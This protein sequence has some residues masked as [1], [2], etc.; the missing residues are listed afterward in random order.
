MSKPSLAGLNPSKRILKR[1][2]YE[3]FEFS[4]IESDILVRNES[5]ADPANHE[6]RVTIEERVPISCECP[7][8]ETY[9]GPCKHR[10][11]VAIRQPI[12]DAAQRVQMAT[13]G[14]VS[15]TNQ[16]PTE[17]SEEATPP[18]CDCD[19]LPDDFPCWEC[20]ESGRRD[21]PELD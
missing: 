13:D 4:L 21:I 18:N 11:A 5:H 15:N 12:I 2:Q 1:A 3:A 20:V 9:S 17:D 10:V 19:E 8:D 16:T 6:Y 7:A 14:G